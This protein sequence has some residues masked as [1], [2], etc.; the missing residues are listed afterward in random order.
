MM[1][2]H[3]I[4]AAILHLYSISLSAQELSGMWEVKHV[5]I[6]NQV[7]TP[8]ARWT[9]FNADNT[10]YSGNGWKQHSQGTFE[11]NQNHISLHEKNGIT[12]A[13]GAFEILLMTPDSMIWVRN[14]DEER[15]HVTFVKIN[16]K[17]ES[18]SNQI[19][20]LWQ[21]EASDSIANNNY[22]HL[23][24]DQTLIISFDGQTRKIGYWQINAHR[25]ILTLINE[26][27]PFEK[28]EIK[29]LTNIQLKLEGI[30]TTNEK[31]VIEYKRI[32][33]FP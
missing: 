13:F 3:F 21:R 24:W 14:E 31:E 1:S 32:Y 22:L 27:A 10:Y 26:E 6:G 30:S 17:P 11:L 33:D 20:G 25:P 5:K 23:R 28:W 12:D 4:L 7:M 18:L 16:E 9:S 29:A 8:I 15:V 19:I 2:K